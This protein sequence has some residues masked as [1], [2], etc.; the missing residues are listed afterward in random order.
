VFP[1]TTSNYSASRQ[2]PRQ[3]ILCDET[4]RPLGSA[5]LHA[6]HS[7]QGQLHL[8]FSV[9]V[10]RPDFRAL[11]IQQRSSAKRLWP[12]IWANTCC[13][14]LR[15]GEYLLEAGQR[16]LRE[17]MG[18][19]CELSAGP[20]F[21]YRA[22]DPLGRGVEH[23][24]DQILIGTSSWDPSPDSDEVAA[25]QW[26]EFADLQCRMHEH[27]EQFAPWFHLG[28]PLLLSTRR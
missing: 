9:Y 7:G 17:E 6:A 28:L 20:E 16:R 18:L 11:L 3:V 13:S 2:A 4:G 24:F 19:N 1:M 5:D 25:W 23:E 10:F 27:P 21:A 14:H 8:A 15:E 12:L 22:E 26:I